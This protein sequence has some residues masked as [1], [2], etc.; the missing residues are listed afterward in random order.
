MICLI[1]SMYPLILKKTQTTNT[2][3]KMSQAIKKKTYFIFSKC[4]IFT[5]YRSPIGIVSVCLS[6]L[7]LD[8]WA[9]HNHSNHSVHFSF[10]HPLGEPVSLPFEITITLRVTHFCC[11]LYSLYRHFKIP[12]PTVYNKNRLLI[13]NQHTSVLYVEC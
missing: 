11:S 6:T 9:W 13:S 1:L 5:L 3:T 2:L 12:K 4:E 8:C 7:P 10:S